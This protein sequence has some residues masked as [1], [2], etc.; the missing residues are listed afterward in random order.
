MTR[1]GDGDMCYCW[2]THLVCVDG[3]PGYVCTM[4]STYVDAPI[5][6]TISIF[7]RLTTD[8]DLTAQTAVVSHWTAD[9]STGNSWCGGR[10]AFSS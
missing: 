9:W 2:L 7:P 4:Y 10:D 3:L 1:S 5:A 8:D 6:C